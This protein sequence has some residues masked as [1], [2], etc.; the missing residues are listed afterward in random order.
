[1]IDPSFW[2]DEKLGSCEPIA[3]LLFMGLISQADDEGRLKGHPSLIR[4]TVFPYDDLITNEIIEGWLEKLASHKLIIR[5]EIDTQKYILI[6]N[7]KKHQT[8]NKPQKSKLPDIPEDYGI[9]TVVV[10]EE[11]GSVPVQKK[12]IE[13]KLKEEEVKAKG[14]ESAP[15]PVTH[16]T[17]N[18]PIKD[19]LHDLITK[20][21]L[22]NYN[23]VAADDIFFFIG[24]MDIEVIELAIKKAFEKHLNYAINTLLDWMKEGKVK[25]EDH[26]P[27]VGDNDA[28]K[29]EGEF[30]QGQAATDDKSVQAGRTGALPSKWANVVQMQSVSG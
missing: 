8:I 27:Q 1:M 3:R 12:L 30:R 9:D 20:C 16:S 18:D 2:E 17:Y 25:I 11:D 14:I 6:K 19:R 29:S 24:K 28:K 22:K 23:I 4:S 26:K 7:F 13:E 21:K 5:Y 10:S 15:E